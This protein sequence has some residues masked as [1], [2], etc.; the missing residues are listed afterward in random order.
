MKSFWKGHFLTLILVASDVVAFSLV[1]RE[2]WEL[3]ANA[4]EGRQCRLREEVSGV[5]LKC[6][7]DEFRLVQVFRNLLENSLSACDDPVEIVVECAQVTDEGRDFL[8]VAVRD[9]GPGLN[10]EQISR[11][12]EPFY[13]T[14]T[15]GTGLGMPIAQRILRVHGGEIEVGDASQGAEFT[16]RLP[17]TN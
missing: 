11:V 6:T 13:T 9:N 1:W 14:K 17:R 12:F 15:K 3:L 5:D 16:I 8:E 10:D 2:A 7:V 4:R